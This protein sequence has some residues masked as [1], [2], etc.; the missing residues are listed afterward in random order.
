MDMSLEQSCQML[1]CL[2][3]DGDRKACRPQTSLQ[4][5]CSVPAPGEA[6]ALHWSRQH[7]ASGADKHKAV[8]VKKML[9]S[10]IWQHSGRS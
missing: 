6:S 5:N 8:G 7:K 10:A 1:N 9:A 4:G 3:T 2:T